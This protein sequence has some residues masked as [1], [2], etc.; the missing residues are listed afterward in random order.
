MN[1]ITNEI[2]NSISCPHHECKRYFTL[3]WVE[4]S[5]ISYPILKRIFYRYYKGEVY[6]HTGKIEGLTYYAREP[7]FKLY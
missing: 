6:T 4:Y 5:D 7:R 2:F 3:H 1:I